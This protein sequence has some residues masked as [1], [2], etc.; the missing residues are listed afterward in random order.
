MIL[1]IS[2]GTKNDDTMTGNSA[3]NSLIG[4]SGND[5]FYGSEGADIIDGGIGANIDIA[6][7]STLNQKNYFNNK[8]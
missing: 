5:L 3:N 8:W 7:Y 2:N 4:N 6:N 1:R